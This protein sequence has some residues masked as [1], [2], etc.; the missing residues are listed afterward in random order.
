MFSRASRRNFRWPA[1]LLLCLQ[2]AIAAGG[3]YRAFAE[4]AKAAGAE[5]SLAGE[6]QDWLTA[7]DQAIA[8]SDW[9]RANVML[10]Y[11]LSS[12]GDRY[13]PSD[14]IDDTDFEVL[15]ADTQE[16]NGNFQFA[17][18]IRRALLASRLSMLWQKICAV[19]ESPS[20]G[21]PVPAA[22]QP[23]RL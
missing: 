6:T 10:R 15:R 19:A 20:D 17:A 1:R 2:L 22:P 7:A 8:M 18:E 12:L 4:N 16:M 14:I 9:P 11:G 23:G 5:R 3:A 21:C 13:R